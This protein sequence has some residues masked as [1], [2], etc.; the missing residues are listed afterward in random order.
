MICPYNHMKVEQ[1]TQETWDYDADGRKTFHE[2][3]LIESRRFGE[4]RESDCAM[5]R[6]GKCCYNLTFLPFEDEFDGLLG[7]E[8]E[9][10]SSP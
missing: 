9:E 5:W 10:E 2:N 1:V 7:C 6:N 8:D 3:K 4:C